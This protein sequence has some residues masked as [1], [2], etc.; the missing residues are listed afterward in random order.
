MTIGSY[1]LISMWHTTGAN[2]PPVRLHQTVC[3]L[4]EE[5]RGEM[6]S[7]LL[8]D[9]LRGLHLRGMIEE[10]GVCHPSHRGRFFGYYEDGKLANIA[11]LGHFILIY[12][13]DKGLQQFAEKA[14]EI[15]APAYLVL[16]PTRQVETFWNYFARYGRE[17]RMTRPQLWYV[18]RKQQFQTPAVELELAERKNFAEIAETQAALI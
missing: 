9:T 15:A 13:E 10:N 1:N 16:G 6:L 12:R 11:L 2:L 17:T 7:L 4:T 18:C 8:L 14:A 5:N 3:E